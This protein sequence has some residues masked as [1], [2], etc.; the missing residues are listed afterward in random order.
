MCRYAYLGSGAQTCRLTDTGYCP[1]NRRV[2]LQLLGPLQSTVK[3]K[4][5]FLSLIS[6]SCFKQLIGNVIKTARVKL[7][8]QGSPTNNFPRRSTLIYARQLVVGD[9]II[10]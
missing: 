2:N 4:S 9:V 8:A 1:G 10:T 6:Y 7:K 3:T 5:K